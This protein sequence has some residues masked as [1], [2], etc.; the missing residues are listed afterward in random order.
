MPLLTE[1]VPADFV[2]AAVFVDR[3]LRRHQ[4]EMRRALGDVQE[5]RLLPINRLIGKLQSPIGPQSDA[6]P[7]VAEYWV[8]L[9]ILLPIQEQL[10][11]ILLR[12]KI[13]AAG[14]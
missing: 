6:V 11:P 8:V 14:R 7:R 2:F 12:R 9:L 4:R 10:R 3:L 5:E 13:N 1:L